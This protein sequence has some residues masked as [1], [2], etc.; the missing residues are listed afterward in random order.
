[1][2][3]QKK[4]HDENNKKKKLEKASLGVL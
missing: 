3:I 4:N 1:L 2:I